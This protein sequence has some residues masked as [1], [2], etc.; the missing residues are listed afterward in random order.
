MIEMTDNEF[1]KL[2]AELAKN[3][4]M[5]EEFLTARKISITGD[6]TGSSELTG[7]GDVKIILKV[8]NAV[9][10]QLAKEVLNMP[11]AKKAID[12][13]HA[14]AADAASKCNGNSKT[15]TADEYGNNI[16]DTYAR[17]AELPK[18]DFDISEYNGSPCLSVIFKGKSYRFIGE[19]V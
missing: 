16:A 6:A 10:A 4:V 5:K 7:T 17:K 19:E 13:T 1:E 9:Q 15:A 3:F 18:V 14:V 8:N 12:A 2:K 11:T